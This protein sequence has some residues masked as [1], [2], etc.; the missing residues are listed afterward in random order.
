MVEHINNED[1]K[2]SSKTLKRRYGDEDDETE[3]SQNYTLAKYRNGRRININKLI[4]EERN[5]R[6]SGLRFRKEKIN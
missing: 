4:Y 2:T 1:E 3:D 5:S 6:G